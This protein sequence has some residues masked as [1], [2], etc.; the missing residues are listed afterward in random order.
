MVQMDET[1]SAII[2][3]H[4]LCTYITDQT[5]LDG[6]M[7]MLTTT[8]SH[9]ARPLISFM[10]AANRNQFDMP[11]PIRAT[12]TLH[13]VTRAIHTFTVAAPAVMKL[14]SNLFDVWLMFVGLLACKL[15]CGGNSI[16]AVEK[17]KAQAGIWGLRELDHM[18]QTRNMLASLHCHKCPSTN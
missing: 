13:H 8:P 18:T 4:A 9:T 3:S 16:K 12:P 7:K 5:Q 2:A 15:G 10:L 1:L 11:L 17:E 14:D 6:I